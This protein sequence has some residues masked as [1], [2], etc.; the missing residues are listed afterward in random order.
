M[1]KPA[2]ATRRFDPATFFE[3]VAAGRIISSY[4]KK[5]IIFAQGDDADAVFYI[6]KGK[7]KVT[8]VS[9]QGKELLS[10]SKARTSSWAKVA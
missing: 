1:R 10:Q 7:V 2:I 9:T 6:K 4:P 3:T 5:E 8:V